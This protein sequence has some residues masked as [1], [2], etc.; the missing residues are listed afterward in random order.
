MNDFLW[1]NKNHLQVRELIDWSR[2]Y[3]YLPRIT[4]DQVIINSLVNPM[5]AL[6]EKT[7]YLADDFDESTNIYVGWHQAI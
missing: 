7:F 4:V 6:S 2:K 1:K 3:L 5:A